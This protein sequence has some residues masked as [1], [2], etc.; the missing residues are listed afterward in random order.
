M[1]KE[2]LITVIDLVEK[3]A[4]SPIDPEVRLQ[5]A[6]GPEGADFGLHIANILPKTSLMPHFHTKGT[7]LYHVL[8]GAGLLHLGKI[9]KDRAGNIIGV[10]W[11]EPIEVRKG[12][13][14]EIPPGYVHSFQNVSKKTLKFI[15][16]C[17]ANHMVTGGDRYMIPPEFHPKFRK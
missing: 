4:K 14:F 8:E 2:P 15:F 7:E 5:H 12:H 9:S 16:V 1:K 11:H 3:L 17:P 10:V 6:I 13:A